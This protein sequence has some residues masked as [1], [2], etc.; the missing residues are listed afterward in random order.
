MDPKGTI[1][2]QELEPSTEWVT[3]DECNT[4]LLYLPGFAKEQLR[5]QLR[6]RT[7][8]ITGE[9]RLHENT[10]TRFRKEFLVSEH[11]DINKISAKFEGSILFV[12][13]PR[14]IT[15]VAKHEK[16]PSKK[17]SAP[18][19][20]RNPIDD[21]PK[22]HQEKTRV[23]T[24]AKPTSMIQQNEKNGVSLNQKKVEEK[25]GNSTGKVKEK[26]EPKD[27]FENALKKKTFN[28]GDMKLK[29]SRNDLNKFF[30]LVVGFAIGV[31]CSDFFKSWI[32]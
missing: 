20:T 4:L 23:E 17:A 11:C 18:M 12:K 16:D 15:S 7:L 1:V 24:D 31:Y 29:L 21:E 10:W 6:S 28:S 9:R 3:E 22:V 8:I 5:V 19:P 26:K 2:Y 30:V 25:D 13:Q 27:V 14:L 32:A